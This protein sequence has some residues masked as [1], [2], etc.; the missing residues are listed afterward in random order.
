[1]PDGVL[2]GAVL[3]FVLLALQQIVH[4]VPL[5]DGVLLEV[6]GESVDVQFNF[7]SGVGF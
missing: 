5:G 2:V 6:L 1:M 3:L 7:V 4:V